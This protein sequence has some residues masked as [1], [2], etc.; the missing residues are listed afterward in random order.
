MD[1]RLR[2]KVEI[3]TLHEL[4][5][6]LDYYRLLQLDPSCP[7]DEIGAAFRRESRRLH[8]DRLAALQDS[9]L[10]EKANYIFTAVNEAFRTLKDPAVRL[11]YDQEVA[12]GGLRISNT[13]LKKADQSRNA[14][15]PEQ[16]ATNERSEKF[17]KLAMR[18]WR[19][20][21]YLSC[22]QNIKFALQ[23]EPDNE[24]FKEWLEKAQE[25][26]KNT[27]KKKKNPY[28]LRIV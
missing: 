6:E 5:D 2:V 7:Q 15:D 10:K 11:Q 27:A 13:A 17:W 14:D 8:P 9:A 24:V 26:D 21:D 12:N 28:K 22:I 1:P 23:F 25:E 3:E 20:K 19:D 16:A 18:S 4:V